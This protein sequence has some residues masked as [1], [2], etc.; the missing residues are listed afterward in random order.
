MFIKLSANPFG[1]IVV[2]SKKDVQKAIICARTNNVHLSIKSG[3]HAYE[4]SSYGTNESWVI[5]VSHLTNI[6]V[7]KN[8]M[9]AFIEPGNTFWSLKEKLWNAG[10]F[11][12]VVD[13]SGNALKELLST[14]QK[15]ITSNPPKSITS[16]FEKGSF[17][18]VF[19]LVFV[20]SE[21]NVTEGEKQVNLITNTFPNITNS[22]INYGSY[23]DLLQATKDGNWSV[24]SKHVYFRSKGFYVSKVL[25]AA[26]IDLFVSALEKHSYVTF[27]FAEY[28]GEIGKPERT[29][30]AYVHRTSL[31]STQFLFVIEVGSNGSIENTRIVGQMYEQKLKQFINEVQFMSDGEHYQNYE[32]YDL[33][34]WFQQYF[35]ENGKRL[36]KVKRRYDRTNF[37]HSKQSIPL[38]N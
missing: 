36:M 35:K 22:S 38:V 9:T 23:M 18:S 29:E 17:T 31:Y 32:D 37:F 12:F 26:E 13:Y 8:E 34:D 21:T 30:T 25:N 20:I 15:W 16:R 27:I 5:N 1:F 10:K 28:G 3:G 24:N 33:Q 4:K 6:K 2:K 14:W 7:N 11:G 19:R